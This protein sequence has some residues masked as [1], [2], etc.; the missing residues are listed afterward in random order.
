MYY[1][2]LAL[3]PASNKRYLSVFQEAS[4]SACTKTHWTGLRRIVHY[5][6]EGGEVDQVFVKAI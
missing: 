5:F 4:N 6:Y 1:H 3:K 2:E